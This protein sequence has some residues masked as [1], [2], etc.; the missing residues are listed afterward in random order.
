MHSWY[1][2]IYNKTNFYWNSI[3]LEHHL[4]QRCIKELDDT[5]EERW[6]FAKHTSLICYQNGW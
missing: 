3:D 4:Q 2:T 1:K 5:N 6:L